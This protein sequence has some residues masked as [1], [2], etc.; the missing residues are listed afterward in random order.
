M[1][2][3][4]FNGYS[5]GKLVEERYLLRDI[6]ELATE[7][8]IFAVSRLI[9]LHSFDPETIITVSFGSI[10]LSVE[11]LRGASQLWH[12][13]SVPGEECYDL[14]G[15][16]RTAFDPQD[17]VRERGS[18]QLA[19]APKPFDC[20]ARFAGAAA[21]APSLSHECLDGVTYVHRFVSGDE[22]LDAKWRNPRSGVDLAQCELVDAYRKLVACA[23]IKDGTAA[24]Q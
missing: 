21:N 24:D 14:K 3:D 17:A 20:T 11:S 22:F 9:V 15:N 1:R 7:D 13:L 18:V 2:R 6:A 23:G 8:G 10:D 12:A 19:F 5:S 4:F 16:P